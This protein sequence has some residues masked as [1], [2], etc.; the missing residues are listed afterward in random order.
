MQKFAPLVGFAV[1]TLFVSY[2]ALQFSGISASLTQ[3][4]P[5]D[6]PATRP[7]AAARP[8]APRPAAA[9]PHEP[10]YKAVIRCLSDMDDLLDT[11][12]GPAS[13]A[14]VKPKLLRRARQHAAQASE[15]PDQGL[16]R[17][18]KAAAKEMQ[19][20]M[21]RHTQA[22]ARAIRVAPEVRDF[23]EKDIAAVLKAK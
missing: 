17:L 3:K 5:A 21:N 10:A 19:K 13:F 2:S 12:D 9:R 15:Y 1:A 23:F 8:E 20:A 6:P 16:A 11:I 4:Q 7:N 14:A 22:L 18:S